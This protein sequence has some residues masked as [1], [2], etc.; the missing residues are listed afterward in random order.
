[1]EAAM[2]EV[3]TIA[4]AAKVNLVKEDIQDWYTFLLSLNPKGKTSMLQDIEAGRETEVEIF[5]GKMIELGKT[6]QIAT[7]VNE[8]LYHAI[9]VIQ[10]GF[11]TRK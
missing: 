10:Q 1:M 6:Y 9:K 7:P 5:A 3:I 4:Q 2:N 11:I 8:M